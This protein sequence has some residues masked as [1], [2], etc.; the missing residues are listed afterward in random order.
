[1]KLRNEKARRNAGLL[2]FTISIVAG[3]AKLKCHF[4]DKNNLRRWN[5]LKRKQSEPGLDKVKTRG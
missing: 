5:R 4:S 2:F 1:V 3:G